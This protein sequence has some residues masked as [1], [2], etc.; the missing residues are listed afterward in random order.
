MSDT[1]NE[2]TPPS[3]EMEGNQPEQAPS[4]QEPVDPAGAAVQV[5]NE[6]AP[7]A[8][9]APQEEDE[10]AEGAKTTEGESASQ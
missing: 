7:A 8:F 5:G 1:E 6:E 4:G 9:Q 3:E 10:T 2:A